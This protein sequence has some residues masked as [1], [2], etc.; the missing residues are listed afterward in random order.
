MLKNNLT[1]N[2]KRKILFLSQK[3]LIR[4]KKVKTKFKTIIIKTNFLLD[5]KKLRVTMIDHLNKAKRV[6][7]S[8]N[9]IFQT[10]SIIQ[11]MKANYP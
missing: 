10:K 1:L 6:I 7:Q 11:I 9:Q 5:L 8:K 3:F 2:I 4:N